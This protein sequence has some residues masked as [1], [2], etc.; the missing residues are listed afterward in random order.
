MAESE[1]SPK[2]RMER[3]LLAAL[4][5]EN[6]PAKLIEKNMAR[7]GDFDFTYDKVKELKLSE[8]IRSESPSQI[9]AKVG[10]FQGRVYSVEIPQEE[11]KLWITKATVTISDSNNEYDC[12]PLTDWKIAL[13][14]EEAHFKSKKIDLIVKP[15]DIDLDEGEPRKLF[16]ILDIVEES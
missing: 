1:K 15:F 6:Y 9:T 3:I 5:K 10:H 2:T 7:I 4:N 16:L 14:I 13:P 12:L 11:R 8:A